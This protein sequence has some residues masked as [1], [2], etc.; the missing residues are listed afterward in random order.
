MYISHPN[1][2]KNCKSANF[3]FEE[4]DNKVVLRWK[5]G[6]VWPT[7][8]FPLDVC[9]F[10]VKTIF[11]EARGIDQDFINGFTCLDH[12]GTILRSHPLCNSKQEW[13]DHCPVK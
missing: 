11:E 6:N 2:G 10:V 13:Y 9:E 8:M 7:R 12:N 5:K 3:T 4:D 1:V